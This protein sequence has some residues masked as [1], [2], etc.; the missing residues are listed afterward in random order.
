[1]KKIIFLIAIIFATF[2]I[3]ASVLKVDSVYTEVKNFSQKVIQDASEIEVSKLQIPEFNISKSDN[4]LELDS[5][6]LGAE[7]Y[8]EVKSIIIGLAKALGVGVEFVWDILVRQQRV[9]AIIG[10]IAILSTFFVSR[11]LFKK[12]NTLYTEEGMSTPAPIFLYIVALVLIGLNT[13]HLYATVTG[14]INPEYGALQEILTYL[15]K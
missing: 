11:F 12:A 6:S 7:I 3:S 8:K 14:L 4:G 13:T 5:T 10:I 9:Y 2:E 1:M 15:K